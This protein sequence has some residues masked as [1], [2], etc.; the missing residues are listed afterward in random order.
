[1]N[2]I[3]IV[4]EAFN[5]DEVAQNKNIL[6]IFLNKKQ[7]DPK[8]QTFFSRNAKI[9]NAPD[10]DNIQWMNTKYSKRNKRTRYFLG[11]LEFV[12]ALYV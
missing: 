7:K 11:L 5:L 9:K 12:V 8:N 1:M 10:A 6:N 4:R 3:D 2:A